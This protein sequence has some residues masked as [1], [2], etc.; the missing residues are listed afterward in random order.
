MAE[1]MQSRETIK[2]IFQRRGINANCV[3]QERKLI[4]LTVNWSF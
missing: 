1:T 2:K 3:Y 4:K